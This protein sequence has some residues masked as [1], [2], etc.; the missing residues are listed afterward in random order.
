MYFI[1]KKAK[2]DYYKFKH[3]LTLLNYVFLNFFA[4]S[5]ILCM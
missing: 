1:H 5:T 3:Y 2:R 4:K